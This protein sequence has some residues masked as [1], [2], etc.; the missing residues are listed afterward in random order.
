MRPQS[1]NR[2]E[3]PDTP[4]WHL[5]LSANVRLEF[6]SAQQH[7]DEDI[8]EVEIIQDFIDLI[9][10]YETK[11]APRISAVV[12]GPKFGRQWVVRVA[13]RS[14]SMDTNIKDPASGLTWDITTECLKFAKS[15]ASSYPGWDFSFSIWTPI[16]ARPSATIYL[17]EFNMATV[18]M[19]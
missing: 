1:N 4:F 9:P 11:H 8:G 14:I 6:W 18:E 10:Y 2:S 17:G 3:P 12:E 13:G 7:W 19:I 5:I 15:F 16:G